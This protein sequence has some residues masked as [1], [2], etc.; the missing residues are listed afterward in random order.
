MSKKKKQEKKEIK[1]QKKIKQEIEKKPELK[2]E[3]EE[4]LEENL[5]EVEKEFEEENPNFQFSPEMQFQDF[6][7]PVLERR[8]APQQILEEN[9]GSAPTQTAAGKDKQDIVYADEK[10]DEARGYSQQDAWTLKDQRKYEEDRKIFL[11][12][13]RETMFGTPQRD[14]VNDFADNPVQGREDTLR[15]VEEDRKLPF[16]RRDSK[17]KEFK[18]REVR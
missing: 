7:A 11:K 15:F 9:L 5:E 18:M 3:K 2:I 1:K 10:Y 12:P 13:A 14:I 6:H 17:Y 8:E 4:S 16:E